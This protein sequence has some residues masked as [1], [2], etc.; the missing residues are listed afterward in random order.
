VPPERYA[1]M[2]NVWFLPSTQAL[3]NMLHKLGLKD[4]R[5]VDVTQTTNQEQRATDWMN[6]HSLADFLDP[7]DPNLSAEG[8]PAPLRAT[9]VATKA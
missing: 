5:T 1:K 7:N 2:S 9:I 6:F 3:E 8:H 4:I